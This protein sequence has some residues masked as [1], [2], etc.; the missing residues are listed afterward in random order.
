MG[1]TRK[2]EAPGSGEKDRRLADSMD[3]LKAFAASAEGRS[4]VDGLAKRELDAA[5]AAAKAGDTAAAVE[6]IRRLMGTP[7]GKALARRVAGLTGRP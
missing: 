2:A 1:G 6:A 3:R 4:A 7:E 5:A